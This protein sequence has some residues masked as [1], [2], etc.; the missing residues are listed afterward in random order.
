MS[1]RQAKSK[2]NRE[3]HM[4]QVEEDEAGVQLTMGNI[5][6]ASLPATS[7]NPSR[8]VEHTYAT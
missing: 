2:E 5:K 3:I 6:K 1:I 8:Q 4:G 7:N